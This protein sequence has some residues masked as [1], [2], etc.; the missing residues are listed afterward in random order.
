MS[1]AGGTLLLCLLSLSFSFLGLSLDLLGLLLSFHFLLFELSHLLFP[2][3][4][5]FSLSLGFFSLFGLLLGLHLLL[6]P[7]FL[8][9]EELG[10]SCDLGLLLSVALG[11]EELSSLLSLLLV[12]FLL[13][14]LVIVIVSLRESL[15]LEEGANRL[16]L[17]VLSVSSSLVIV[18]SR[19][20]SLLLLGE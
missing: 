5:H 2:L 9:S 14:P 3:S 1:Q 7:L 19:I 10:L 4:H 20:G 11:L 17:W 16:W 8:L 13:L 6:F 18:R 12:S 15:F